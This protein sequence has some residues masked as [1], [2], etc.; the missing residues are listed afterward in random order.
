MTSIEMTV[1]YAMVTAPQPSW[2]AATTAT[3]T[4]SG[5]PTRARFR[6]RSTVPQASPS[7]GKNSSQLPP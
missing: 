1:P 7:S 2:T 3:A 6:P 5:A 4:V